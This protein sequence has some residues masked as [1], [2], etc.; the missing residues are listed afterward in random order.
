[1]GSCSRDYYPYP[2]S[3]PEFLYGWIFD[4]PLTIS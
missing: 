3:A 4:P 2:L 1:M